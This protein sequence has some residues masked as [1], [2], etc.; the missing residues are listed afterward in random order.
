MT[1]LDTF[2]T[3]AEAVRTHRLRS[4]LTMLGIL[5]GITAV[6][7]TVGLGQGAQGEGAGPDQRA[8]HQP[9]RRLA[10]E[11]DEQ[12]RR[13]RRLRFRVDADRSRTRPRS[14][15]RPSAPDI[16]SVAPVSSSSV[17]L[18]NGTTNWTTT[19]T[20]TTPSWRTVRSRGVTLGPVHH[21]RRRAESQR[22]SSSSGPDTASE[23]FGAANPIGR[24]VTFNG[25][26]LEVIGVLGAVELVGE[27]VEQRP[28]DR[29]ALDV[30]AAA[31]RWREPRLGELDLREG[32]VGGQRCRP[33]TRKP[34]RAP[35]NT[36][37]ITN[38]TERRLLDRDAAVDP[39][40]GE[41]GRRHAHGD[42]R[43]ASPSSRCSSAGSA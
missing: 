14:R 19:L 17:S 33:R 2:R 32:D 27:R 10:R 34:T 35:A 7:L 37:Q 23:L 4:A 1:W 39:G 12:H 6:V 15:R 28:R 43:A 11:L 38:A 20:G 41:L 16:E 9:A 21:R 42:A 29:S 36:H 3:A 40:G 18:V 22:R 25:T 8:R 26:K 5:I 13:P 24:T 31:G 30:S